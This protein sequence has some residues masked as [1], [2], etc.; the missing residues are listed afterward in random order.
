MAKKFLI[1]QTAFVGDVILA[2]AL[3]EKLHLHFSDSSITMLVR[4][5]NEGLLVNNPWLDEV[6]IWSKKENKLNNLLKLIPEIRKRKFDHVINLQRFAGTGLLTVLSGAK[7]TSGFRKNPL[8]FF[9][10]DKIEHEIGNGRHEVERNQDLIASITNGKAARMRLYP[11]ES[12]FRAVARFHSHPYFTISPGSIWFTK[13]FPEHKWIELTALLKGTVYILGS[14]SESELGERII[15]ANPT[16]KIINLAGQLSFLESTALMRDAKMNYVN[17][18][19]P[20]HMAG[21]INAPVTAI[22]CSTVPEFGFGPLSDNS[23]IVQ[24]TLQLKCRPCG[25]HGHQ[26]CPEKHF[27]CAESIDVNTI[28]LT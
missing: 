5:G 17:D 13:T 19:A 24:T 20:L 9:Y 25:L 27:R 23:R 3:I 14:P 6:L 15:K 21:A 2:T 16:A 4:K 28:Q 11:S 1:I 8:S 10:S 26:Q 18:S 12:D 22:Y 7:R